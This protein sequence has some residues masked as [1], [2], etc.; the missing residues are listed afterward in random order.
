[1]SRILFYGL[2][3][4]TVRNFKRFL[5]I[6]L[7]Y[8]YRGNVLFSASCSS[9]GFASLREESQVSHCA[10]SSGG[11]IF[12]IAL[13]LVFIDRKQEEPTY[14]GIHEECFVSCRHGNRP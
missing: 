5:Q 1:M 8:V 6:I 3:V 13:F 11:L 2:F 9:F 7:S 10:L 4:T 14:C 12:V